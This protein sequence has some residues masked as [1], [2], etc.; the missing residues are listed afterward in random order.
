MD[1]K[2]QVET[3]GHVWDDDLAEY[4]NPLPTWW[5]ITFY[6]TVIF[7]ITY[8]TLYPSWPMGKGFITGVL[9]E[10][11]VVN[12][13]P[14]TWH[15]NTRVKL[16]QDL[17]LSAEEQAKYYNKI[18][19]MGT[20]QIQ[21]D[22][23]LM[24]FVQSAGNILFGDNCAACHR[25]GGQGNPGVAPSLVD[26]DWLY[27]GSLAKI[28][29][30][31]TEGRHGYMP[32]F[33]EALKADEISALAEYVLS[34]SGHSTDASLAEKGNALFHSEKVGCYGCHGDNAKGRQ[35]IGSAN[36][37][38]SIWLWAKTSPSAGVPD[39]AELEKLISAGISRGVMPNWSQR[40]SEDQIKIVTL[41]VQQLGGSQ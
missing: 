33:G 16:M 34:L 14:Q 18:S 27:G 26:D 41:Y 38:D 31:V 10:D 13:Q 15:W 40:L 37:T 36:L 39:R 30:T 4:N 8:W 5:V 2:R 22:A 11:V 6:A 9:K 17:A 19:Q 1:E 3:T 24:G 7:A 32:A 28:Q 23:D 12:G 35:E 21:Q 25:S 20:D 29:E